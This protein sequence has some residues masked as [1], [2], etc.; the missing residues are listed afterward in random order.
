MR[1]EDYER[2]GTPPPLAIKQA[3]KRFGNLALWQDHGYDV[4]G[5]AS[6]KPS[7]RI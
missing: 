3:Q 2:A 7:S 5:E 6:W 1:A 4:R